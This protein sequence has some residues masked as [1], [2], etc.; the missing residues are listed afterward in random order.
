MKA[1]FPTGAQGILGILVETKVILR[2]QEA[3]SRGT[4]HVPRP[5]ILVVWV[6]LAA[7][8]SRRHLA[9]RAELALLIGRILVEDVSLLVLERPKAQ[10]HQVTRQNPDALPELP[11]HVCQTLLA[12][13]EA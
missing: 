13:H 3:R 2:R 8:D 4:V 5:L 9:N 7:V 1:F 6:A 11:T 12:V 10:E